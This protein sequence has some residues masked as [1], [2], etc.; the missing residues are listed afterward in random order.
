MRRASPE[1]SL[2]AVIPRHLARRS[3][4]AAR[5][6]GRSRCSAGCCRPSAEA[7][8]GGAPPSRRTRSAPSGRPGRAAEAGPSRSRRRPG[9]VA[10]VDAGLLGG[11]RRD[12]G[13][14]R[15]LP[16]RRVDAGLD[17]RPALLASQASALAH[18]AVREDAVDAG[19]DQPADLGG[20][21]VVID[22]RSASN[23]VTIAA[24]T[25]FMSGL[26]MRSS[27]GWRGRGRRLSAAHRRRR[28]AASLPRSSPVNGASVIPSVPCPVARCSPSSPGTGPM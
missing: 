28:R 5:V 3:A 10:R 23:G 11:G 20:Q 4:P 15:N 26:L 6:P 13:A 16:R 25:P 14:H 7:R 18:G 9:G 1:V 22:G 17:H 21:G 8:P 2:I 24:Y 27:F 12:P 19:G